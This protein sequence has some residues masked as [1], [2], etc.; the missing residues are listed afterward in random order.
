MTT[1][2]QAFGDMGITISN[3]QISQMEKLAVHFVL[4]KTHPLTFDGPFLGVDPIA[5][6]PADYNALFD[7]FGV[8]RREFEQKIRSVQAIDQTFVVTSDPFNLLSIWLCHLAPIYIRDKRVCYDF[9][10]N[11]LRYFHYKIFCSC[12]NNAFRHGTNRGVMEATIASL[13]KK[14]D[15]IR[16]E[17]WRALIDSHVQKMLDPEDRFYKTIIDASPD[18]MF[19]RV[20]SENQTALRQKIITFANA[21]YQAHA[22]GDKMGSMSAIAENA[23]GE[24]IIAQT[25]SVIDSA[26]SAMVAQ[27]L[28]PNM[29]VNDVHVEDIAKM[30]STI[31][32]RML[33]TALLKINETAALQ[34]ASRKFDD[35]KT[36]KD[37]VLYIGIRALI[38]E[39]IRSMISTLRHK[40]VN[41]GNAKE[42]FREMTK[43]YSSSRNLDKDIFNIKNS[44]SHLVDPFN[45]TANEASKS[46][47][48]LAVIYYIIY[49]TILKMKS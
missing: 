41:M 25:A 13:S 26:T 44:V 33:K 14:S 45:I 4:R 46:A 2:A 39:I 42:M 24:K 11:V 34:A 27:I 49:R 48:R 19:L 20:I 35:V 28:N 40:G 1:I 5:F 47:L 31:S 17:S 38:V 32:P 23:D 7:V 10:T 22:A 18:D 36:S 9:M 37:S 30:F 29:F 3:H 21:Y 6:I 15:I 43:S 8:N 12:V 16:L